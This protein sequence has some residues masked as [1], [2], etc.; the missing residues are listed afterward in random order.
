[1][2]RIAERPED[3]PEAVHAHSDERKDG[4][5]TQEKQNGI[6]HQTSLRKE[7]NQKIV[8]VLHRVH[9]LYHLT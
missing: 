4:G 6:H 5:G 1:V 9:D 8:H 7:D 2:D 3:S